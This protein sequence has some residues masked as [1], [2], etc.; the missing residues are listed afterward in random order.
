MS[1]VVPFN[2]CAAPTVAVAMERLRG[3]S[4][5]VESFVSRMQ[6]EHL[7]PDEMERILRVFDT[8]N[9][10]I[11]IVLSDFGKEPAINQLIKQSHEIKALIETARERIDQLVVAPSVVRSA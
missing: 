9:A 1:N 6:L 11:R 10:C 8:A 3:I 4:T 7:T 5:E 2:K